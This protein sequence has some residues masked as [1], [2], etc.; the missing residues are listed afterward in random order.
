[1]LK[2][3]SILSI[4]RS[5]PAR[6]WRWAGSASLQ[7]FWSSWSVWWTA[8]QCLETIFRTKV[9]CLDS[10]LLYRL[11]GMMG[12][13]GKVR[14][15][16][17]SP[18]W[19]LLACGEGVFVI[20]VLAALVFLRRWGRSLVLGSAF[21]LWR[22]NFSLG[23]LLLLQSRCSRHLGSLVAVHL[24]S[25]AEACGSSQ[26]RVQTHERCNGRQILNYCTPRKS[27]VARIELHWYYKCHE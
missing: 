21:W 3:Q 6:P 12:G 27:E 11:Q 24:P 19:F 2:T 14:G 15:H 23:W 17:A 9:V 10:P 8:P 22:V 20:L 25:C 26:I 4:L 1:M 16:A 18:L 7:P 5:P 13:G